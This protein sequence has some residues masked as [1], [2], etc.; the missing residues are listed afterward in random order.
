MRHDWFWLLRFLDGN[1]VYKRSLGFNN[2]P[3][4]EILS[5]GPTFN[6]VKKCQLAMGGR[7]A[8]PYAISW[9]SKP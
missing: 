6:S 1:H 5:F 2:E 7:A 3:G 8:R 9:N 4:A